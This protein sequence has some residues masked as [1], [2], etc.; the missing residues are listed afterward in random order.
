MQIGLASGGVVPGLRAPPDS[1]LLA[2]PLV[3]LDPLF[4]II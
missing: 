3:S 1:Q 4:F 2:A